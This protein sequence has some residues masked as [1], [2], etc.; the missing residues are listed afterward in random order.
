MGDTEDEQER[1]RLE[2]ERDT[3]DERRGELLEAR[4]EV[5]GPRGDAER[6]QRDLERDV[7]DTQ[8]DLDN[9]LDR[10]RG[11]AQDDV[12]GRFRDYVRRVEDYLEVVDGAWVIINE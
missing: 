6:L 9:L 5:R 11:R 8:R 1:Q 12:Y 10:D 3:L 4:D 2:T 7:R